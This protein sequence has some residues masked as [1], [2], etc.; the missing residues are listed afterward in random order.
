MVDHQHQI[1]HEQILIEHNDPFSKLYNK[2]VELNKQSNYEIIHQVD[3]KIDAMQ[4]NLYEKLE[5]LNKK[6]QENS[7]EI[8]NIK[9]EN[10]KLKM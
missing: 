5:K 9:Q 10:E 2:I 3:L 4:K 7:N 1:N 6:I 8:I